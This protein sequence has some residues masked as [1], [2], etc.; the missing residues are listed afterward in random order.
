[1]PINSKHWFCDILPLEEGSVGSDV[2]TGVTLR[3]SL[4]RTFLQKKDVVN[5]CL[6][7]GSECVSPRTDTDPVMILFMYVVLLAAAA[8]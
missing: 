7:F 4:S 6:E 8:R 2:R 3:S 5:Q 1:M